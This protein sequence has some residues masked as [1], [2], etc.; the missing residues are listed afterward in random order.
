MRLA[1]LR[2]QGNREIA[3]GDGLLAPAKLHEHE[4][5]VVPGLRRT[6]IQPKGLG[7][8]LQRRLELTQCLVHGTEVH[9]RRR[10]VRV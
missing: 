1:I 10:V 5:A 7:V 2:A 3:A 6:R 4:R 8:P 9:P